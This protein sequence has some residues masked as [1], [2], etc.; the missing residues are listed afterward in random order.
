MLAT[1]HNNTFLSLQDVANML[2]VSRDTV[3]R[4]VIR[5]DLKCFRIGSQYRFS[6][7]K[8]EAYLNSNYKE[9]SQ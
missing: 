1:I 3:R 6:H 7:S 4:L 2:A 9:T 5:G 8:I